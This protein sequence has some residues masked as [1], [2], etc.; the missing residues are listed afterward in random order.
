MGMAL[1]EPKSDDQVF[2]EKGAKYVIEKYI[3]EQAKPINVDFVDSSG[4]SGFKLTS[5]L[6]PAAGG[7]CGSC[8]C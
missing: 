1:D 8:S 4:G 3:Y 5:N 2:E 6:S 7:S